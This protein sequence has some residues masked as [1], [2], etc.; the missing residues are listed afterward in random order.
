MKINKIVCDNC[1]K[2]IDLKIDSLVEIFGDIKI[3]NGNQDEPA[4]SG[5]YSLDFCCPQC[6][7][8]WVEK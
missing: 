2:T 4:K 7:K 8:E 3:W 1:N 6:L 5:D